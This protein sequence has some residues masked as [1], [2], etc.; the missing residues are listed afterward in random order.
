M[1]GIPCAAP[2]AIFTCAAAHLAHKGVVF[3]ALDGCH[4]ATEAQVTT[5]VPL[6]AR[7]VKIQQA[8]SGWVIEQDSKDKAGTP[9]VHADDSI[10][11]S[12]A[13]KRAACGRQTAHRA[14]PS[15]LHRKPYL[16][17]GQLQHVPRCT[18]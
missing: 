1:A 7:Q 5:E 6:A 12:R 17:L 10:I 13:Q 18:H 16:A 3:K 15:L 11:P 14:R 2:P 9:T 4:L 8:P